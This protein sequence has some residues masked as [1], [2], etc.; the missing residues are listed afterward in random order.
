MVCDFEP[1]YGRSWSGLASRPLRADLMEPIEANVAVITSRALPNV[2]CM[3][4]GLAR[5]K[6][7]I[8]LDAAAS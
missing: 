6:G 1:H 2:H 3:Q 4:G 8:V 7:E 5:W